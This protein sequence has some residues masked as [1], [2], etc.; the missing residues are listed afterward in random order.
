M[1]FD[2]RVDIVNVKRRWLPDFEVSRKIKLELAVVISIVFTSAVDLHL[3]ACD[4]WAIPRS[5]NYPLE[6]RLRSGGWA[7][8]RTSAQATATNLVV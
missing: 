5:V 1:N 3:F 4:E 2:R 6:V 7:D 8:R